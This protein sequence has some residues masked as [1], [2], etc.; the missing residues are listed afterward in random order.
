MDRP[1]EQAV[2]AAAGLPLA[3]GVARAGA[4]S[5]AADACVL[6]HEG[7]LI[8]RRVLRGRG[9]LAFLVDL[10]RTTSLEHGDALALE[11]G[12]LV[13]VVAA[14]EDLIE[15]TGPDLARLAWHVGNRHAPCQVEPGRLLI[16]ADPV[17]RAMLAGLGASLRDLRAPFAPEGGAYGLGSTHAHAR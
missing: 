17:L 11:D 12:R 16:R 14:E 5:G 9:G 3:Q 4:W 2:E 15:V 10:A 8:R 1:G 7:R 13:E 6:D